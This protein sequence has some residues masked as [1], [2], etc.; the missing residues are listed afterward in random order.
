MRAYNVVQQWAVRGKD[1]IQT[2][3]NAVDIGI[4]ALRKLDLLDSF[5]CIYHFLQFLEMS[6]RLG[7]LLQWCCPECPRQPE[8]TS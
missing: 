4:K 7:Y 5:N 2:Q 1:G 3:S 8:E 6:G